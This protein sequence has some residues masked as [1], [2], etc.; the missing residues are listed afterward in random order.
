MTR[1]IRAPSG[2]AAK[3]HQPHS[4]SS[5]MLH[6]LAKARREIVEAVVDERH[7]DTFGSDVVGPIGLPKDQ[8]R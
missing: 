5:R 8:G 6:A 7:M 3:E 4:M 1:L 2:Q